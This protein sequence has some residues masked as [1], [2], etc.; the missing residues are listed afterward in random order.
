MGE[1]QTAFNVLVTKDPIEA[2]CLAE[3][4]EGLNQR[5]KGLVAA[6]VKEARRTLE[7]RSASLE[8]PL[9]V[10]GNPEWMPGILGLAANS[11][12]EE[13]RKPAFLWGRYGAP[14]IKG[15]CRSDGTVNLVE[16]MAAVETGVF[17]DFGG[18]RESGGF[19][20]SHERIHTL[21]AVL[22]EAHGRIPKTGSG[23]N[24]SEV[25]ARLA[26]QDV[27]WETYRTIEQFA[28]FGMGNPKPLFLFES[29][30][31]ARVEQ[32][33]RDKAHLKLQFN[34][35]DREERIA[36]VQ[37]IGFFQRVDQFIVPVRAGEKVNLVAS[38]ECSYFRSLPELRLRIVDLF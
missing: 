7:A 15:S 34:D 6:M 24:G 27:T 9:L 32:F 30:S 28:P 1:P 4:L 13:Y 11:L 18:H 29:L 36:A 14:H 3:E 23:G 2:G 38:V 10:L 21:E 26:L 31:L 17:L 33:G 8:Q 16:L 19:S 35:P 22:H 5:R 37:A 20:I 25:D 12:V